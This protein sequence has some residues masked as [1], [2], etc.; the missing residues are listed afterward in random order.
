MGTEIPR[1]T[2]AQP[3]WWHRKLTL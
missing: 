3:T 1:G 2:A